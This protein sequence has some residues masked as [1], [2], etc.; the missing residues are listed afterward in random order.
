MIGLMFVID[1]CPVC[2]RKSYVLGECRK[3]GFK[4]PDMIRQ[5]AEYEAK[6]MESMLRHKEFFKAVVKARNMKEFEEVLA[7]FRGKGVIDGR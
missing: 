1:E 3:C 4:D 7:R 5:L 6:Y 2:E